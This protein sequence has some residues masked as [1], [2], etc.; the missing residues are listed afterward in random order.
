MC[1]I[2]RIGGWHLSSFREYIIDLKYSFSPP[3]N[4]Y[5]LIVN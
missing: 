2:L 5:K 1:I 4:I 3:E